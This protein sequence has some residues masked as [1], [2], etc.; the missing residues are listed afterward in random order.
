MENVCALFSV[1]MHATAL[2]SLGPMLCV[3]HG[4]FRP[5]RC[6]PILPLLGSRALCLSDHPATVFA[7]VL[8]PVLQAPHCPRRLVSQSHSHH[9]GS[10]H[11]PLPLL[12]DAYPHTAARIATGISN[13]VQH[14]GLCYCTASLC[15]PQHCCLSPS[16]LGITVSFRT[17]GQFGEGCTG[18]LE[19]LCRVMQH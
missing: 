3:V 19:L 7:C 5:Y 13:T 17:L 1:Y 9:Y 6:H 15:L 10:S 12:W 8:L 14:V 11:V 18:G 4:M 2:V 16:G